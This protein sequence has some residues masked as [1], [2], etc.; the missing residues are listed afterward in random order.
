MSQS[1]TPQGAAPA[2]SAA[3]PGRSIP[4]ESQS[5]MLAPPLVMR[6][7]HPAFDWRPFCARKTVSGLR[8]VDNRYNI[9][10]RPRGRADPRSDY[11]NSSF[12]GH[13]S[14]YP[15]VRRQCNPVVRG[16]V[17]TL[18]PPTVRER[19]RVRDRTWCDERARQLCL[20]GA[21]RSACCPG[22]AGVPPSTLPVLGRR[23][24]VGFHQ[25]SSSSC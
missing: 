11:V 19:D 9:K 3:A 18:S 12:I 23:G 2:G 16:Y 14:H 5:A 24:V 10:N 7:E 13:I 17:S 20:H 15:S 6:R 21:P 4:I 8:E 22:V 25:E 1:G